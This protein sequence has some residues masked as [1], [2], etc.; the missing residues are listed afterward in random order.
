MTKEITLDVLISQLPPELHE[1]AK[2]I[3]TKLQV[4]AALR[5]VDMVAGSLVEEHRGEFTGL[6]IAPSDPTTKGYGVVVLSI[7]D[8]WYIA[9]LGEDLNSNGGWERDKADT[10]VDDVVGM[11]Q[12]ILSPDTKN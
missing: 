9:V 12:A 2:A 6:E 11:V 1:V 5:A 3:S 4:S 7:G 8:Q 10:S